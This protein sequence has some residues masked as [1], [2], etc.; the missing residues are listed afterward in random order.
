MTQKLFSLDD[1]RTVSPERLDLSNRAPKLMSQCTFVDI[2]MLLRDYIDKQRV[3]ILAGRS[4]GLHTEP[5]VQSLLNDELR[6]DAD[7]AWTKAYFAGAERGARIGKDTAQVFMAEARKF[8]DLQIANN[9][10]WLVDAESAE[11]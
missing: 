5:F 9:T 8:A 2:E 3:M 11:D 4:V 10:P 1:L 7:Y 6:G